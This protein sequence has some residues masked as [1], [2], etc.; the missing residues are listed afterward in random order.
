VIRTRPNGARAAPLADETK[1]PKEPPRAEAKHVSSTAI[2]A[3]T[4]GTQ[5]PPS[6]ADE[7]ARLLRVWEKHPDIFAWDIFGIRLWSRQIEIVRAVARFSRTAV[8]TGQKVGKSIC[9][10]ILAFWWI[11]IHPNG[12]VILTAPTAA[13]VRSTLWKEVKKLHELAGER[14]KHIG[15][16]GGTAFKLPEIGFKDV[17][18]HQLIAGRATNQPTR[19]QGASGD[20]QLYVVDEASGVSDDILAAIDGNLMGGGRL[21][22]LGNPNHNSGALYDAFHSKKD[23]YYRIQV[24]SEETPNF[25]A[26]KKVIKG[27]AEYREI[28]QRRQIWG[29]D[30]KGYENHYQYQV[31]VQGKFPSSAAN[32]VVSAWIIDLAEQRWQAFAG[33]LLDNAGI[34]PEQYHSDP[35]IRAQVDAIF[36]DP[37]YAPLVLGVDPKRE[38][39]DSMVVQARRGSRVYLPDEFTEELDGPQA[40]ERVLEVINKYRRGNEWVHVLVDRTG[41]GNSPFDFLKIIAEKERIYLYGVVWGGAPRKTEKDLA[42]ED[43]FKTYQDLRAELM[44]EVE[45]RLRTDLIMQPFQRRRDDLLAPRYHLGR[46]NELIVEN[47]EQVRKRLNGKSC[48][49]YDALA[50][51]LAINPDTFE[52]PPQEDYR[53]I[54]RATPRFGS[55]S[56]GYG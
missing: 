19:M 18:G 37:E 33:A 38:G 47:K 46:H 36:L 43:S 24:S 34:G 42:G 40:K 27:L 11:V 45:R 31:R 17:E 1:Q 5:T 4:Y 23:L 16:F 29:R 55:S 48:D 14:L 2:A 8:A 32:Q 53:P 52:P 30:G 51:S 49:F 41:L 3:H 22:L 13:Q 28:M 9:A 50:I 54:H 10:A 21:L 35:N 26:R 7:L 15:G 25:I 12:N 20:E 39:R 6:L 56:R 44:F